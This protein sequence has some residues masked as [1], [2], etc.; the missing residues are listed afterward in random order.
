MKW[1]PL[2]LVQTSKTNN[3]ASKVYKMLQLEYFEEHWKFPIEEGK[4]EEEKFDMKEDKE[5]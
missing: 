1:F 2:S 3:F 5:E 4:R